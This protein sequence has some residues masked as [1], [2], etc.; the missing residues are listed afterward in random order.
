MRIFTSLALVALFVPAVAAADTPRALPKLA[1]PPVPQS[2]S[3]EASEVADQMRFYTTDINKCYLD[4]AGQVRGAGKL[5]IKLAIH[6][7]GKLDGIDVATPGLPAR[8]AKKIS[9]CVKAIVTDTAFPERR[10]PTTA[11]V[12]FFYQHTKAPNSGPQLSCWN[13]R[14][15]KT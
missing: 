1:K 10:A 6:R 5:E 9:E 2:K 12:P 3:L 11:I 8:A 15:C 13:P 14:G 4:A 7:T